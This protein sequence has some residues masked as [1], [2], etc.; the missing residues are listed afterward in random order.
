MFI[1][2]LLQGAYILGV[3]IWNV[4][5]ET[6]RSVVWVLIIHVSYLC[7]HYSCQTGIKSVCVWRQTYLNYISLELSNCKYNCNTKESYL[8]HLEC[9]GNMVC[10]IMGL[11]FAFK[12][13]TFLNKSH[14]FWTSVLDW[15][16]CSTCRL[17]W[18]FKIMYTYN[19]LHVIDVQKW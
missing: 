8:L 19:S 10:G 5:Y 13:V 2:F 3:Y 11:N 4:K 6:S 15:G 9:G 12:P 7:W 16:Y 1:N 17:L 14:D 18:K